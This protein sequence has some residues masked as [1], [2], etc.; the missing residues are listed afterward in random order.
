MR[1]ESVVRLPR[2]VIDFVQI[3]AVV[4]SRKDVGPVAA[5]PTRL[6][7]TEQRRV[8]PHARALFVDLQKNVQRL[9]VS[10]LEPAGRIPTTGS[11][12]HMP[13]PLPRPQDAGVHLGPPYTWV[14][15]VISPAVKV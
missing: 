8:D 5:H 6:V 9:L 14:T 3:G 2:V 13:S 1:R 10:G 7:E 11:S 12:I 4:L 15:L